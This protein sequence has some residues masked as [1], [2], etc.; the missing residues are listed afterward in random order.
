[1]LYSKKNILPA[2]FQEALLD[3]SPQ[4]IVIIFVRKS[5]V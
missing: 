4:P 1:M 5:P 2:R 3:G